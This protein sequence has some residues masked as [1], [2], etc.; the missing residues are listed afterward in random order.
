[1]VAVAGVVHLDL[2]VGP[3]ADLVVDRAGPADPAARHLAPSSRAVTIVEPVRVVPSVA[4]STTGVA[5]AIA[6]ARV[7]RARPPRA[8][9]GA[10]VVVAAAGAAGTTRVAAATSAAT[11]MIIRPSAL[12]TG[13]LEQAR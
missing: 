4:T 11:T 9:A 8:R 5:I 3:V 2:P 6:A 10:V 1:M 12:P 7:A 13:A